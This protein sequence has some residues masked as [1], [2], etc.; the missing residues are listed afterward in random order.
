MIR[1]DSTDGLTPDS[2]FYTL[3]DTRRSSQGRISW[4][5]ICVKFVRLSLA[6]PACILQPGDG[7]DLA[8]KE[9]HF[10]ADRINSSKRASKRWL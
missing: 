1:L 8:L 10:A 3:L 5:G 9:A 4:L 7:S 6:R 2:T